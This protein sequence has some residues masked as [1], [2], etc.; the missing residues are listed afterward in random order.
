MNGTHFLWPVRRF[1]RKN[2][3]EAAMTTS[4]AMPMPRDRVPM[5]FISARCDRLSSWK[6]YV[7]SE[8]CEFPGERD[9]TH[10]LT[11]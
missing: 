9:I 11:V 4:V 1:Q 3:S 8:M 6:L 10:A 2:E 5:I 7:K